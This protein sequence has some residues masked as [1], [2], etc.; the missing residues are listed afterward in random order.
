MAAITALIFGFENIL[1]LRFPGIA[2]IAIAGIFSYLLSFSLLKDKKQAFVNGLITITSFY[3]VGIVVEAPW[4]IFTHGFMLVAIY[5]LFQLF[6]KNEH[7]WKHTLIAGFFFGLS[8]LSKGP[9][10]LYALL[11]PFLIAYGIVY[12][13]K[14]F[15]QKVFSIFSFV[16]IGVVIGGWW[17][18]YV[19]TV[20]PQTF[21]EITA[22]ETGNWSNYNVRPFYYYWSFFTQSGLWT[23]PAFIALLYPYMKSR[24]SNLKAYK[25]SFWWTIIGVILLSIIPE[26]KSRYLMPVL[27]PMAINT[28]FYIEY[29][30]RRFK[31]LIDKR[32]TFPVYL[33]FGL[34]ALIGVLIPFSFFFLTEQLQGEYIGLLVVIAV[35][36]P[37][38]G[39]VLFINLKRENISNVIYACVGFMVLT[40][41]T[42]P[43]LTNYLKTEGYKPINKQHIESKLYSF[44]YVSPE[45]IWHYGEKIPQ[46]KNNDS[47]YNFPSTSP[48][49]IL[50]EQLTEDERNYLETLYH[51]EFKQTYSLNT[52]APGERGHRKRLNSSYYIL[53]KK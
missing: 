43:L 22:K 38:M 18:L 34:V 16:L 15:K 51:V 31:G 11:L 30:I 12:R 28:G 33:N 21:T 27:L 29:L 39:I 14:G 47:T 24:V 6:E 25:L 13:Y 37:L 5:H 9:I 26:K 17:Y 36:L 23:I 35:V 10:S 4:D 46:L 44:G 20:D 53:T 7:Y 48:F 32:E 42:V 45:M 8:I 52:K 50:T 19:R 3:V 40:M 41:L 1:A 2:M 49:G